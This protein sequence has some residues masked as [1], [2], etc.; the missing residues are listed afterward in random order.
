MKISDNFFGIK[1]S[2]MGLSLQRKRMNLISENIANTNT[3][4]TQ[5]GTPYQRKFLVVKQD[6]TPLEGADYNPNGL[7]GGVLRMNTT[8]PDH[9]AAAPQQEFPPEDSRTGLKGDVV[10]DQKQGDMVYMPEHPDAD[11]DGYVHMPNV[12]IVTEMVDMI[13]ATRSYESN[14]TALNSSKQM[15]K[16]TLEI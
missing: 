7:Q 10:K 13:A 2:A 1:I 15:A 4:K 11:T 8:N 5:D 6:K 12:N 9:I 14:L 16:D 3:T